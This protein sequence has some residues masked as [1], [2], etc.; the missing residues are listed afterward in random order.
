MSEYRVVR[1]T[2]GRKVRYE[3]Q[4]IGFVEATYRTKARALRKR[5]RLRNKEHDW[6]TRTTEVIE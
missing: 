2:Q 1:V 5:D 3:V 6:D 4:W